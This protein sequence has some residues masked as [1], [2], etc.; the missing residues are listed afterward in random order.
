MYATICPSLLYARD[1]TDINVFIDIC[2][3]QL[4]LHTE[5]IKTH[6][7][8]LV[9]CDDLLKGIKS[10]YPWR[11]TNDAAWHNVL[12][13]LHQSIYPKLTRSAIF[14]DINDSNIYDVCDHLDCD[15]ILQIFNKLLACIAQN[16]KIS[17]RLPCG[18]A[19]FDACAGGKPNCSSFSII[20]S[21]CLL[22]W[23]QIKF[24]WLV[25]YHP[26]LPTE[27]E[28]TF[29]PPKDWYNNRRTISPDNQYFQDIQ[30]NRWK[31]DKDKKTHFDVTFAPKYKDFIHIY[32]DGRIKPKDMRKAR[33]KRL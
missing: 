15:E 33:K 8:S 19:T 18:I 26:L 11:L 21:N 32:L 5:M 16:Y 9:I 2:Y 1:D 14:V 23:K 7:L 24:P 3:R 31:F 27:G 22:I 6:G 4:K 12:S 13:D 28:N 17:E 25:H 30:G 10:L 20:K 29:I